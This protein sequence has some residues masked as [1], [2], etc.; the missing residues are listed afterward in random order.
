M[1]EELRYLNEEDRERLEEIQSLLEGNISYEDQ[2]KLVTELA[3]L[4]ER[5]E[6]RKRSRPE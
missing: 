1:E 3:I 5:N 6:L 2:K 4:R